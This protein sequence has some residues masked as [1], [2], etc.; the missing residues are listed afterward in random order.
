[1]AKPIILTVDDDPEVLQAIARDLR[2]QYGDRFRIVRADSG[3][4]AIAA[5]EKLKLR[6]ESVA[7]FLADQRMPYMNG[8]EF[9]EQALKLFPTAKRALLTGEKNLEAIAIQNLATGVVE[10]VPATSLFIFIGAVPQTDWLE[11]V[12]ERDERGF[13]LAGPDLKQANG[14]GRDSVLSR[15][16]KGWKLDRDLY[17]LET[18]IAGV[19]AVGDVRHGSVKRVASGVGEGSICVQF[20][21]QYLANVGS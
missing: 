18:N 21:H 10:I 1:M 5:V 20:V 6:N 9:L 19:F 4:S 16:P 7:L 11:G 14:V 13:I 8:I 17:L 15:R 2:H 12:V 3:A